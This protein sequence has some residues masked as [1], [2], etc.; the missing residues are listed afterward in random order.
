MPNQSRFVSRLRLAFLCDK[1]MT[2]WRVWGLALTSTEQSFYVS[3][4]EFH[5]GGAA[6]VALA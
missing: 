1:R 5:I 4:F 2:T 3:E 6:M